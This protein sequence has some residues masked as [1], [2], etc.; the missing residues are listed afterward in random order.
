[1][2]LLSVVLHEL[3]LALG[4]TEDDPAEPWVMAR[5]LAA[6]VQTPPRLLPL[7]GSAPAATG[8]AG[9]VRIVSPSVGSVA[10]G[11]I[12]SESGLVVL[13]AA[14]DPQM[15]V[16]IDRDIA[17]TLDIFNDAW[18][19]NWSS[20]PLSE[21]ELRK[22]AADMK[23]LLMPELTRLVT[24]EGAARDYGVVACGD[25][26]EIDV[27]ATEA[28]RTTLRRTRGRLPDVAWHAPE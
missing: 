20:V 22:T 21:A 23:L 2:D 6:G 4:F 10:L 17:M 25:P 15:T 12:A 8:A 7:L 24:I 3:G 18:S 27:A 1:M 13:P 16:T 14:W 28:L 19:D 9:L 26:P 5:T 11:S